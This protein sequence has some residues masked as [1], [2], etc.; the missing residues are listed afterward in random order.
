MTPILHHTGHQ[1]HGG[2]RGAAIL[3]RRPASA[4][5]VGALRIDPLA[6]TA[7]VAGQPLRL[8][9][10]QF[11]LLQV[12]AETPG[13]T[14]TRDAISRA[15]LGRPWRNQEDRCV[16]LLAFMTRKALR[17]VAGAPTLLGVR[18]GGYV[19]VAAE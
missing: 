10:T 13:V 18:A 5:V 15:V 7:T 8:T 19:L 12:L 17:Q 14:V 11:R 9:S 4:L 6:W 16:D 1:L 2:T 3:P